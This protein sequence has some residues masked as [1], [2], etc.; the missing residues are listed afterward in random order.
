MT[1]GQLLP[2]SVTGK[3][4][5]YAGSVLD[6]RFGE[7]DPYTLGVEEEYMLLDGQTLER[8]QQRGAVAV[9]PGEHAS[10]RTG[11]LAEGWSAVGIEKRRKFENWAVAFVGAPLVLSAVAL[12]AVWLPA[13]RATKV[14]P[15]IALRCE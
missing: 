9:R 15:V 13:R 11:G 5:F 6:H 3:G 10:Q 4:S 12:V 14:D 1:D 2:A 7:G 8:G